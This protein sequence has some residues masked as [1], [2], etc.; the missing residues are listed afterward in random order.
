MIVVDPKGNLFDE[1]RKN[2]RRKNKE[3]V[4]NDRRDGKDRR[5]DEWAKELLND[6]EIQ[7]GNLNENPKEPQEE[8]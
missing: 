6:N 4:E 7:E 1:R 2:N 3:D 8:N 5:T